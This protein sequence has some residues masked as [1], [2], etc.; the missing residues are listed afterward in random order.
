MVG[1]P[2][3]PI[4]QKRHKKPYALLFPWIIRQLILLTEMEETQ[5]DIC[6][7]QNNQEKPAF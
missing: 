2:S 7:S 4:A 5:C 3:S 6:P 1:V